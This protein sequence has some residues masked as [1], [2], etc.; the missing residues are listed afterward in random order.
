MRSRT[1]LP[2]LFAVA[3]ASSAWAAQDTRLIDA[4]KSGNRATV[5]TL[6]RQRVDANAPEPDGTTALHWAVRQDDA[7]TVDA[8]LRAG[9]KAAVA[10]RYGSTPLHLACI[11]GNAAIVESLIKAGVSAN[12][13]LPDGETALMTAARTGNVELLKLLISRGADVNAKEE[14][15]GQTALMWAAAEGNAAAVRELTARGANISARSNAGWTALLFAV[16]EGRIEAT[17][18]LL[19]AGAKVNEALA[20]RPGGGQR[21]GGTTAAAAVPAVPAAPPALD[22][23]NTANAF[24]LAAANAHYELATVLLDAGADPN[25]DPQGWTALHQ[26]T[27]VRKAGVGDNGPAPQGSGKMGSLDF[28]RTLV[29]RGANL[30]ARVKRR[31]QMG[32]TTLNA[33]GATPFLLAAR[34][35]DVELMK[36]LA[37]LGADPLLTNEDGTT[38]L[39][40]AAGIG[41]SSPLEDPGSEPEVL[42][43]TKLALKLGGDIN[44]VDKNGETAMHGAAYKH[45]PSV[46]RF[47][48]ENGAKI[49]VWNRENKKGWTPLRIVEGIPVGMNIA[50]HAETRA[51]FKELLFSE[52]R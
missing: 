44:A 22:T 40:V 28:V 13:A 46:V 31:P 17:R 9:A 12:A 21:G 48:A 30:N 29:A 47:L 3:A 50:G 11:N 7:H 26:V 27:W 43:A 4:V 18:A 37:D 1:T 42:E 20:R 38:P 15:R 45:V 49:E 36:L 10:N 2:L 41:T 51:L 25:S 52:L 24:M 8:L 34:T 33:I 14:T 6:L 5:E 19:A 16:R 23:E 32:T 35:K 39:M